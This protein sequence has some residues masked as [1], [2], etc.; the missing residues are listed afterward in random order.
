MSASRRITGWLLSPRTIRIVDDAIDRDG[1]YAKGYWQTVNSQLQVTGLRI[2][3][4]EN[5][6]VAFWGDTI[7]RHPGG[8]YSILRPATA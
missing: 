2:G 3:H 8:R 6:I 4:D 1:I 5:R 7:I